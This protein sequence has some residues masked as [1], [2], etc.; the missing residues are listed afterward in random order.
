MNP[1]ELL[2]VSVTQP[3]ERPV[4]STV[5]QHGRGNMGLEREATQPVTRFENGEIRSC[6]CLDNVVP[7]VLVGLR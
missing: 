6:V 3:S 7:S 2:R 4:P 5:L 1:G